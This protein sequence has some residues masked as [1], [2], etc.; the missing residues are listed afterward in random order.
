MNKDTEEKIRQMQILEQT[1]QGVL[2][3]KQSF[4]SQEMEIDS[5]LEE[6]EKSKES[7][8]IVGNI[9]V[10][11]EVE[12]L[13]KDLKSKKELLNLRIKNLEKQENQIKESATKL[14]SDLLKELG[15]KK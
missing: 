8:K 10:K 6:L 3:Q 9:M 11:T 7:Y 2:V 4:Q 5:A 13:K 12:E 14:Q 1:L 15:P